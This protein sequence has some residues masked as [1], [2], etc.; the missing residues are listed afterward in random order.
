MLEGEGVYT[1]G[2]VGWQQLACIIGPC[3]STLMIP[4]NLGSRKAGKIRGHF[5]SR[6]KVKVTT[7][8]ATV[9][10]VVRKYGLGDI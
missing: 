8:K 10:L 4:L 1:T 3:Y 2:L 9:M 5:F 6:N 7:T